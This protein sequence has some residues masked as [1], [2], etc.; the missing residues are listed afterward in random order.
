MPDD[1]VIAIEETLDDTLISF[2]ISENVFKGLFTYI[3]FLNLFFFLFWLIEID[4]PLLKACLTNLF[5]SKFFPLMPKK[6]LFFFVNLESID[7]LLI[8]TFLSIF[9][10]IISEIIFDFQFL[11]KDL[12][13]TL[14]NFLIN[15]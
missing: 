1:P 4:A 13:L 12:F 2:A 6:I 5:P 8:F 10:F 3:S 14:I 7:A 11:F 15:L 9:F